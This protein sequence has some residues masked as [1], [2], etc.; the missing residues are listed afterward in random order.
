MTEASAGAI[1]GTSEQALATFT[2]MKV[3]GR[4]IWIGIWAF[5]F[6]L[7]ASLRWEVEATG[8]RPRPAEIWR[9]FPKFVLGFLIASALTTLL[10][11]G[12][13]YDEYKKV[14]NPTS[15]RRS[16]ICGAGPLS[17]ASSRLASPPAS[18]NLPA[19]DRGPSSASPP[20]S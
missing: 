19:S 17:S 9:R 16:R 8:A 1:Q 14:V 15:S 11:A 12:Y 10:S 5:I 18:V 2:L 3:I 20:A 6:A 7:I 4:D 13:P